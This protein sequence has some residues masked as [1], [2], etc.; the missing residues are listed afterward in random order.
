MLTLFYIRPPYKDMIEYL[1]STYWQICLCLARKLFDEFLTNTR[2]G[3]PLKSNALILS[4]CVSQFRS[5]P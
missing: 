1:G 2:E 3:T 4:V 5:C